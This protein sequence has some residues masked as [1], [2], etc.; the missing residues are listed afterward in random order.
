MSPRR[1]SLVSTV[2]M[3]LLASLAVSVLLAPV[4]TQGWCYDTAEL[5]GESSCGSRQTSVLGI[6]SNMWLWLAAM[7]VVIAATLLL[8]R[9]LRKPPESA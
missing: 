5:G 4:L 9:R 3:G 8:L 7:L 1:P 6:E 2:V